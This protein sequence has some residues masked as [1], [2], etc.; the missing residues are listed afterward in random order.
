MS[1][2]VGGEGDGT[3]PS[4]R[5]GAPGRSRWS[6]TRSRGRASDFTEKTGF[7]GLGAAS[8]VIPAVKAGPHPW[9]A[10]QFS[11]E[12]GGW[13]GMESHGKIMPVPA[14]QTLRYPNRSAFSLIPVCC[15]LYS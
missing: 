13:G 12:K 4:E 1:L 11:S 5:R 2:G 3:G 7:D 14:V 10:M 6:A 15:F 8:A 9:E